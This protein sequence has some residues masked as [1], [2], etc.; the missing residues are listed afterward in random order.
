M[1]DYNGQP[2]LEL[3]ILH[4][5]RAI[6]FPLMGQDYVCRFLEKSRVNRASKLRDCVVDIFGEGHIVSPSIGQDYPVLSG[7]IIGIRLWD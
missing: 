5:G 2:G 3:K 7:S 1:Y 6:Q 4:P